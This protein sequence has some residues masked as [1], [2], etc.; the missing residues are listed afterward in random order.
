MVF[1]SIIGC[2]LVVVRGDTEKVL[3]NHTIQFYIM[4]PRS[5]GLGSYD[6]ITPLPR[7]DDGLN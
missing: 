3:R 5:S 6:T 2:E 1:V 7:H 4:L